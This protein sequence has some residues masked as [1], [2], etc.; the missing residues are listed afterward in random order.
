MQERRRKPRKTGKIV[1]MG[2]GLLILTVLI[3][4]IWA[5]DA[6]AFDGRYRQAAWREANYQ[7]QKLDHEVRYWLNKSGR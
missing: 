6:F 5:I 1:L 2:R 4:A 3:G 7:A